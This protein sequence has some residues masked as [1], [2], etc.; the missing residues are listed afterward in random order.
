[1]K[2]AVRTPGSSA[3]Q[4]DAKWSVV[5]GKRWGLFVAPDERDN[6]VDGGG[7]VPGFAVGGALPWLERV[8][9]VGQPDQIRGGSQTHPF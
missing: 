6:R 2:T 9:A 4:A 3:S 7:E 8:V 5:M 1:M